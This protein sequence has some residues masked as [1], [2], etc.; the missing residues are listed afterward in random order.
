MNC[1]ENPAFLRSWSFLGLTQTCWK[2]NFGFRP[3]APDRFWNR[4]AF[5]TNRISLDIAR[6]EEWRQS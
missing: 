4:P 3:G 6:I 5:Y 2:N 1:H